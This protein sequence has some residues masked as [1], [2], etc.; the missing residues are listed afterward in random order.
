MDGGE[1]L[2]NKMSGKS[3]AMSA[4]RSFAH[5]EAEDSNDSQRMMSAYVGA[6]KP[7]FQDDHVLT[8]V[9]G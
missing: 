9:E 8:P 5:L 7:L 1:M 2:S 4:K 3:N 6:P